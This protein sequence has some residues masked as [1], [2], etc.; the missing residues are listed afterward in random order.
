MTTELMMETL[1]SV[2]LEGRE[3][4]NVRLLTHCVTKDPMLYS[5]V[6][7]MDRNR[8]QG[9]LEQGEETVFYQAELRTQL[10]LQPLTQ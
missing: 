5:R 9:L 6:D 1:A 10:D 8:W 7:L 4:P 2:K 3:A